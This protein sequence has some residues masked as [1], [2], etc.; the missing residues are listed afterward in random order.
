MIQRCSWKVSLCNGDVMGWGWLRQSNTLRRLNR[1]RRS[2]RGPKVDGSERLTGSFGKPFLTAQLTPETPLKE[3]RPKFKHTIAY[4]TVRSPKTTFILCTDIASSQYYEAGQRQSVLTFCA[5]RASR[6]CWKYS[7]DASDHC[8]CIFTFS[9]QCSDCTLVSI[10][11]T[12]MLSLSFLFVAPNV[13]S[14]LSCACGFEFEYSLV[15][16]SLQTALKALSVTWNLSI[17]TF[18]PKPL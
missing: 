17:I 11:S 10:S 1:S 3:T 4:L 14:T 8:F 12:H 7:P 13:Q 5:S 6:C 2:E 16:S 9:H 15:D 18:V